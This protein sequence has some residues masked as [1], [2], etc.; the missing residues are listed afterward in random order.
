M[1]QAL[2]RSTFASFLSA[3]MDRKDKSL[4][5]RVLDDSNVEPAPAVRL[6]NYETKKRRAKELKASEE[7]QRLDSPDGDKVELRTHQPGIDALIDAES[8]MLDTLEQNWAES[9]IRRQ[10]IPWGW[11]ALI[12]LVIVGAVLWSL[13]RVEK[14]ETAAIRIR[15][16]TAS[17]IVDEEMEER[18]AAEL[19]D[20]IGTAVREFIDATSVEDRV[21]LV[22]Q[23]E[24][25]A[26]LMR[27]YYADKPVDHGRFQSI[28]M[29]QP[30]TLDNR[31]N[32]W[33][34]TVALSNGEIH[35]L[36]LEIEESGE[37]RVDWETFV[38]H[39]PMPWD[40]FARQRPADVSLDF[41]VY[42]EKDNFYNYEFSNTEQ[43][44]C[45]RL[46]ALKSE[47]TVFGYAKAESEVASALLRQF[48]RHGTERVSLLLRL[49]IPEGLQS[50][51]GVVIEK[52]LCPRWLYLDPPDSGS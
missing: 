33:M 16:E 52:L 45:F 51:N 20:R 25:V 35:S 8:V 12:V 19:I 39:Q 40:V 11:F 31:G 22:R 48:D 27:Q 37:P 3:E 21:R 34:T 38:C 43:W 50:Q 46:T 9:A 29:L 4:Q 26:P 32:F 2:R 30:A 13:T 7:Y 5:L 41:R 17:A 47:E 14:A 23:S 1:R 24:R 18:Q 15:A 44:I 6:D 10:P 49:T 42:L 36:V 28:K